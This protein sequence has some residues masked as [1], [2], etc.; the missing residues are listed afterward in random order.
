MPFPPAP[1]ARGAGGSQSKAVPPCLRCPQV[2]TLNASLPPLMAV[3]GNP[4]VPVPD[5]VESSAQER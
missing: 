2:V 5:G 1:F 3:A 4:L